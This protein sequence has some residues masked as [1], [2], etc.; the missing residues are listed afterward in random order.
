MLKKVPDSAVS[1]ECWGLMCVCHT[2]LSKWLLVRV[3][4]A[5]A[6]VQTYKSEKRTIGARHQLSLFISACC[7]NSWTTWLCNGTCQTSIHTH[8]I[9]KKKT[10]YCFNKCLY[11]SREET[12]GA[13][14]NLPCMFTFQREIPLMATK[15]GQDLHKLCYDNVIW[16]GGRKD[17]Q[18]EKWFLGGIQ[19][20]QNWIHVAICQRIVQLVHKMSLHLIASQVFWTTF[21]YTILKLD[22][23]E[24]ISMLL[25]SLI[26][27]FQSPKHLTAPCK[28]GFRPGSN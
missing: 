27:V 9:K 22:R 13:V 26:K 6:Y 24:N 14:H 11:S 23:E 20:F 16:Q 15:L 19:E 10:S 21:E 3:R 12:A 1:A 2:G 7:W 5:V 4:I 8:S 17:E 28:A 18:K 25:N